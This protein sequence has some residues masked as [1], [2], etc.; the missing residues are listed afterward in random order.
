MEQIYLTK[1]AERSQYPLLQL[2]FSVVVGQYDPSE[3][4]TS[5]LLPTSAQI[6]AP[7]QVWFGRP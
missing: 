2:I 7:P 4:N 3:Q 6:L 1:G 5:L